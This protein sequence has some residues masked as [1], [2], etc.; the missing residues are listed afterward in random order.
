MDLKISTSE[1]EATSSSVVVYEP[2]PRQDLAGPGMPGLISKFNP[3][4]KHVFSHCYCLVKPTSIFNGT[5]SDFFSFFYEIP[6][7]QNSHRCAAPF[8]GVASGIKSVEARLKME[9]NIS[10]LHILFCSDSSALF[11]R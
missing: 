11:S 9:N 7:R 4:V 5:K 8:C 10:K 2:Q 3:F 1:N 6:S